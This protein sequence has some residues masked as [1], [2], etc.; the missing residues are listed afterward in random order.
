MVFDIRNYLNQWVSLI[1]FAGSILEALRAGT[2]VAKATKKADIN[3]AQ[4]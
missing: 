2:Q 4:T 3:A 1:I